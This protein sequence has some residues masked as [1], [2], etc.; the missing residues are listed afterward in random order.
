M[1]K[2]W[3]PALAALALALLLLSTLLPACFEN[4]QT[5]KGETLVMGF[6]FGFYSILHTAAGGFAV[7]LNIAS[8]AAD[9]VIL[10]LLVWGVRW[11]WKKR[12]WGC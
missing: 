10:Y 9:A 11:I 8:L 1:K 5:L 4:W 3:N 7:H 6:P 12:P 2:L